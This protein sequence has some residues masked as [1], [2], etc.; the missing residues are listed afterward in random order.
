MSG[1]PTILTESDFAARVRELAGHATICRVAVGYCGAEGYTFFP[2]AAGDWP[3]DS[4]ALV[5]ASE[6]AV[7]AGLTNPDG[8]TRLLGMGAVIK[9]IKGLHSKVYAFDNTAALVGSVN[10]SAH[11]IEAQIQLAIQVTHAATVT[12]VNRWF[13]SQWASV[14]VPLSAD[15]LAAL[16][17][18]W[19]RHPGPVGPVG[20]KRKG[21]AKRWKHPPDAPLPGASFEIGVSKATLGEVLQRFK[22]SLCKYPG[23]ESET[24]AEAALGIEKW[25]RQKSVEFHRLYRRRSRWTRDDLADLHKLAFLNGKNAAVGRPRFVRQDPR[26][27]AKKVTYLLEG[28]GDPYVRLERVLDRDSKEAIS[29][30]GL[31]AWACLMHLWNP[32][33]F[34][35]FNEPVLLALKA[36]KV[37]AGRTKTHRRAAKYRNLSEAMKHLAKELKL[38]NLSRADHFFDGLGKKHFTVPRM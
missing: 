13:D 28:D 38:G 17:K 8:L 15:D 26:Q 27:L 1:S 30:F 6:N 2:E 34:A 10:L 9:S 11:A 3:R 23:H 35:I 5:D 19:P 7:R 16:K 25:Y 29:G 20:S 36:L 24:C 31:G 33:S 14:E 37:K 21:A 12:A 4:R 22:T 18:L 32:K